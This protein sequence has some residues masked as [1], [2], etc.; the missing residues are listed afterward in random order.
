MPTPRP[1][2]GLTSI[3]AHYFLELTNLEMAS[4]TSSPIHLK[5]LGRGQLPFFLRTRPSDTPG[6]L[7]WNMPQRVSHGSS[8]GVPGGGVRKKKG[9]SP[10]LSDLRGIAEE[11]GDAIFKV[12]KSRKLEWAWIVG[13]H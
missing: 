6:E 13:M 5:S 7:A 2:F 10:R 3:H 11:V 8:A 4:P 12:V 9:E 1:L